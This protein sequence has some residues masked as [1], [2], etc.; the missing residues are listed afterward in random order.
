MGRIEKYKI[1][2]ND[3]NYHIFVRTEEDS[4]HFNCSEYVSDEEAIEMYESFR[5]MVEAIGGE[6]NE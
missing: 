5:K 2:R 6:N 1:E 3:Y 4:M